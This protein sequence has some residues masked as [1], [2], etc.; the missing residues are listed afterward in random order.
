VRG[1]FFSLDYYSLTP[2]G[3]D[4]LANT[5]IAAINKAYRSNIPAIDV[6]S[7]PTTAQ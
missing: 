4:L 5:F 2:R 7:L 1:N 3:N 6:N